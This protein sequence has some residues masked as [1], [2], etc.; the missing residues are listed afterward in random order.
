LEWSLVD[1]QREEKRTYCWADVDE[2]VGERRS[3]GNT[4]LNSLEMNLG[5][6][7]E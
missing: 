2:D 7:V 5:S 4:G 6:S 1:V 3:C